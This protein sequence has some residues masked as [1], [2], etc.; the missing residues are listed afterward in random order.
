MK[1]ITTLAGAALVACVMAAPAKATPL[2]PAT[3]T[4][5]GDVGSTATDVRWHGNRGWRGRMR[6]H[7]YG[8]RHHRHH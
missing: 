7:H 1:L 4:L 2:A 8:W 3:Q 5:A 6:G